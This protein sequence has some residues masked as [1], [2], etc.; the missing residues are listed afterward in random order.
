MNQSTINTTRVAVV[1][2]MQAELHMYEPQHEGRTD[3]L[4]TL[5]DDQREQ[6][7]QLG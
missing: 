6:A 2:L 7:S 1:T 3:D 5:L 4:A